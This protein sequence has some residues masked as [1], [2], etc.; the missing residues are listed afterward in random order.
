M[1]HKIDERVIEEALI[2]TKQQEADHEEQIE[3]YEDTLE[4]YR[5]IQS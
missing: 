1:E 5:H 4:Y 2:E 3:Q